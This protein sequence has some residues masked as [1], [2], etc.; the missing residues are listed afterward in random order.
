MT[1][2]QFEKYRDKLLRYCWKKNITVI[3]HPEFTNDAIYER[4]GKQII[5]GLFDEKTNA[6]ATM[7][8]ELGHFLDFRA[9]NVYLSNNLI[10]NSY[11]ALSSKQKLT[12]KQKNIIFGCETRAWIFA[13]GI[14]NIL[15]IKIGPWFY[16]HKENAL[17]NYKNAFKQ[18][19]ENKV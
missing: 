14:A 15:N 13:E 5:I 11:T 17:T 2:K 18:L 7:L 4:Y 10:D 1:T 9:T 12:T 8:H 16:D 6:I 19:D 3:H